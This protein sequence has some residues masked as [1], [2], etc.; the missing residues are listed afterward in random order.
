MSMTDILRELQNISSP[1]QPSINKL[2]RNYKEIKNDWNTLSIK[3]GALYY[4]FNTSANEN[5]CTFQIVPDACFNILF[6]C[7]PVNPES[8]RGIPAEPSGNGLNAGE[9]NISM[10]AFSG[11]FFETKTLILKPNTEY[12]GFKP[13]SILGLKAEKIPLLELVNSYTDLTKA[14]PSAERLIQEIANTKNFD[15]RIELFNNFS[16]NYMINHNYYPTFVD[17]FTAIICSSKGEILFNETQQITGYSNRYSRERFK[18]IC[19]YSPKKYS[20]IMRFQK[21]LKK[22]FHSNYCDLSSLAVDNGY[23]DQAH[24]IHDFKKYTMTSPERFRK[25][26]K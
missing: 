26:F 8:D 15:Q 1:F 9:L 25:A 17:Y 19:G 18:E 20:S 7:G 22:L 6:E 21:V 2:T 24:F 13:Y 23:F 3:K 14:Y 10:P 5:E 16:N 4:Q 11:P 12:F